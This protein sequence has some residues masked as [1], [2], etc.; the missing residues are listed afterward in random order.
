M[1]TNYLLDAYKQAKNYVQDKQIAHDLGV[2]GSQITKIRQG[3]RFLPENQVI[4]LAKEA[5]IDLEEAILGLAADK[6]KTYEA[7]KILEGILEKL[8]RQGIS[9]YVHVI[10][11]IMAGYIVTL[12]YALDVLC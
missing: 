6:S 3:H 1:Y 10:S 12:E 8:Q 11:G 7:K 9:R 5:N 4:M 2:S